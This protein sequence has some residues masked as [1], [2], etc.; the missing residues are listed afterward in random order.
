M[1]NNLVSIIMPAY[2]ATTY[3]ADAIES[4]LH[5]THPHWELLIIN[6]GSKDNT[7]EIIKPFLSDSRIQYF[8]QENKGVSAARN[9]GLKNMKGDYFC[10]LDADD[11]LPPNSLADR[12]KIFQTNSQVKYVDGVVEKKDHSL[13]QILLIYI[14]AFPLAH[15]LSDLVR[16]TGRS[17][18][19]SSWMIKREPDQQYQFQ[20]GLTHSEDLLF[21]MQIARKGGLYGYTS[22]VIYQYRNNLSSAMSNLEGLEKGYWQVYKTIKDWQEVKGKDLFVYKMKVRK[23]MFLSY[24]NKGAIIKAIRAVFRK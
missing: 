13:K 6:D 12:L 2:N 8:K 11:V 9:V 1:N 20:T 7:E 5:Q 15:P 21:Y 24:L 16:L 17:F 10:F 19:G 14:P 22:E 23:I 4:V 3:I 18:F